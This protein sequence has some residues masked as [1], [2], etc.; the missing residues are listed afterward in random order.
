[1]PTT[2]ISVEKTIRDRAAKKAKA[3]MISFSAVVR[4]LLI[5][6]ANGRIRI[7]SQSV[8]EYQ[9]ERIDVDKKTQNLM[10]EVVSEWNK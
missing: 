3:D 7:G 5:D 1:M 4:V 2:S 6:Y 8:E 9:V 10:D